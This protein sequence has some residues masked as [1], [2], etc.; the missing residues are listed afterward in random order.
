MTKTKKLL[1]AATLIICVL[2][3]AAAVG[4]AVYHRNSSS[5]IVQLSRGEKYLDAGDYENA[6]LCYRRAVDAAPEQ[7]DGYI[8]LAQVYMAQN[9]SALAQ[10]VL[11]TALEKTGSARIQFMI[12]SEFDTSTTPSPFSSSTVAPADGKLS[13]NTQ[14]LQLIATGTYDDYR[15]EQQFSDEHNSESRYQVELADLG[16]ILSFSNSPE[17]PRMIDPNTGRPYSNRSPSSVTMRDLSV[18]FGGRQTVHFEELSSLGLQ[19]LELE[20]SENLGWCISFSFQGCQAVIQSDSEGTIISSAWNEFIPF[21]QETSED[22][23]P[24]LTG[25]VINA[26]TGAVVSGA[27]LKFRGPGGTDVTVES[28]SNG[29]YSAVLEPGVYRVTI[30]CP[31]FTEE[32]VEVVV[33]QSSTIQNLTISPL[34][35]ANEIRF[36]LTWNSSPRDLDSHLRGTS[37]SGQHIQVN[38]T[39]KK[40]YGQNGEVLAELDVDDTDGYGPETVTLYD[41]GG[42]YEYVVKDFQSTGT[43]GSQGA[44]VKIYVGSNAPI[45]VDVPQEQMNEWYVCRIVNGEVE[46][47][48][49][50]IG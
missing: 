28:T 9:K 40:A 26:Q 24:N 46:V 50:A 16:V 30:Q 21:V 17:T 27:K 11:V 41:A 20:E 8:G 10:Q 49:I 6:I 2:M 19:N 18:L 35:Q 47:V 36:V 34:L 4:A 29:S 42:S 33:N 7:A 25:S 15:R 22:Q 31:G 5:Y 37:S 44:T 45:V 3:V 1:L 39:A 12:Q 13:L 38:Y 48:N 43:M 32:T 14:L 23:Q